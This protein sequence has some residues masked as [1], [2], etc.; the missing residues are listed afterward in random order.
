MKES[1]FNLFKIFQDAQSRFLSYVLFPGQDL[2]ISEQL[3]SQNGR[4]VLDLEDDGNLVSRR[5][6]RI[7]WQTGPTNGIRLLMAENG[8]LVLLNPLR[9][10]IFESLTRGFQNYFILENSGRINVKDRFGRILWTRPI[11]L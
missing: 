7:V 2:L 9:F 10:P 4:A 11:F 5:D 6:G 1:Y 8:N 3:F